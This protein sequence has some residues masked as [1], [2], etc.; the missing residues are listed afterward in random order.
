M[1]ILFG[2]LLVWTC[3]KLFGWGLRAA[4]GIFKMFC[5]VLLFPLFLVGLVVAGLMYLALPILVIVLIV[6]L[7][8]GA[9]A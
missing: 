9:A 7:V 3:I 4:W 5:S 2:I 6:T 8:K 1:E